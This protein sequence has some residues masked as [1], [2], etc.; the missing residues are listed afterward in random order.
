M[1][2][3]R[4]VL[5]ASML[6][7]FRYKITRHVPNLLPW[8]CF[9]IRGARSIQDCCTSDSTVVAR[10]NISRRVDVKARATRVKWAALG[11]R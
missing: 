5:R 1:L 4:L 6:P 8:L 3:D 2:L 7:V 10:M 11:I 9:L